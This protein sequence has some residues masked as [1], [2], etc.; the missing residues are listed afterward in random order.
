MVQGG[1]FDLIRRHFSRPVPAPFLGV[2][3]DC[4]LLPV[5]EGHQLAVSTDMLL[6]GR[7][8][9]A[10]SDPVDLGHKALAVNLSDLAA[11]GARPLGCTLALGVAQVDDAWLEGFAH[12]FH[13]LA[14]AS[15]CPLLGGDTTRSMQGVVLCVTVLG[16][17]R[18]E[19]ALRRDAG[20]PGDDIWVSGPLGAA[21]IALRWL[22]GLLPDPE[23]RLAPLRTVLERPQPRLAL[24]QGLSGLA[25]A[26]IDISDG[27]LQDLGHIL[28]ASG[29]A[30]R[31][32][33][34][35][36]PV[37]PALQGLDPD[38]VQHAVLAGGDAYELC[39]TAPAG[40][41]AQIEA[42]GRRLGMA[43]ARIGALV[44]GTG[45][46]VFDANGNPMVVQQAG[47]DHFA[48]T[49]NDRSPGTP[50]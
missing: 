24:G 49:G 23:G 41:R 37:H 6:E 29:C 39:F 16:E 11:M 31:V 38:L 42:L 14:D 7:H 5:Q 10:D 45:C 1:E 46:E 50:P 21:D 36:I 34:D 8:F 33:F 12:G 28:A 48:D 2:G 27:L 30:A 43:L 19:H 47:F 3:D 40:Q 44:R 26:A 17:V 25:H 9:L 4:A 13:A 32:Q 15:H 18:P 20:H 22:Q 35:A